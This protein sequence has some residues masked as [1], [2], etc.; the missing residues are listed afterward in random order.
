MYGP[1]AGAGLDLA[2]LHDQLYKQNLQDAEYKS[3]LMPG[4]ESLSCS[5]ASPRKEEAGGKKKQEKIIEPDPINFTLPLYT[6]GT[7]FLQT[8]DPT[9][10]G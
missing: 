3:K 9:K 6:N 10:A 2:K 8:S 1:E 5:Q 4:E 7:K